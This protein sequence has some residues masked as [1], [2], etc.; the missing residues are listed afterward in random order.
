[1]PAHPATGGGAGGSD[2]SGSDEGS[3]HSDE[4]DEYEEGDWEEGEEEE[5]EEEIEENE[6][7][8]GSASA[9]GE[10]RGSSSNGGSGSGEEDDQ[11]E[12]D[13]G[14][15]GEEEEDFDV[16]NSEDDAQEGADDCVNDADGRNDTTHESTAPISAPTFAFTAASSPSAFVQAPAFADSAFTASP[17]FGQTSAWPAVSS[18]NENARAAP[19][20]S[21]APHSAPSPPAAVYPSLSL[22]SNNNEKTALT[23]GHAAQ[24]ALSTP[25]TPLPSQH[26]GAVASPERSA[27]AASLQF[28]DF[29]RSLGQ[30]GRRSR[31]ATEEAQEVKVALAR[32]ELVVPT[33]KFDDQIEKALYG[34]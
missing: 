30:P 19:F 20:S 27:A 9:S 3:F 12:E 4:E 32:Y 22:P 1:M 5:E 8:E 11:D 7:S 6:Q 14:D 2:R 15:D 28:V 29:K 26:A 16:Y 25:P 18:S 31:T 34:C 21:A 33:D 24:P 17:A 13:E 23:G 10:R